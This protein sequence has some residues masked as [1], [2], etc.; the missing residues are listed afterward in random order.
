MESQFVWAYSISSVKE[1]ILKVRERSA[2]SRK[3]PYLTGDLPDIG[4]DWQKN[5]V[6]KFELF[7][8]EKAFNSIKN[9]WKAFSEIYFNM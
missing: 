2:L 5:H 3:D 4:V 1:V 7:I 8:P 9:R 6:Q